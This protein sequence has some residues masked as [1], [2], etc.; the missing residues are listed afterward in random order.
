[1][2]KVLV[3]SLATVGMVMI[4]GCGGGSSSEPTNS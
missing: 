2:K 1:M 3:S 4:V